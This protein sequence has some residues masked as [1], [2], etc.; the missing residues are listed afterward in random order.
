ADYD[1]E[2]HWDLFYVDDRGDGKPVT[3]VKQPGE[4]SWPR[5]S[6]DQ[7][8]FAYVSDENGENEVYIK[9]FPSAAG[10]W[11]V[12][13]GGGTWPR[14]RR[15]GNKLYYVREDTLMEV[16]VATNRNC[17]SAR[18]GRYSHANRSAGI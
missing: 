1:K 7:R 16:E 14:G 18:P 12:S 4:Q 6:R 10:K 17:A 3:L 5:L 9:R 11:Q 15:R 13:V 2:T 8:Y